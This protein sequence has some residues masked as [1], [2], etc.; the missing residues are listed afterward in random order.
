MDYTIVLT[1]YMPELWLKWIRVLCSCLVIDRVRV[2][3]PPDDHW[4]HVDGTYKFWIEIYT[5]LQDK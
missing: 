5:L 4:P 2:A 3:H 1:D